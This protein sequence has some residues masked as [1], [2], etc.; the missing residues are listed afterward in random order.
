MAAS[1]ARPTV[2]ALIALALLLLLCLGPG[3]WRDDRALARVI[4]DGVRAERPNL[5]PGKYQKGGRGL[6]VCTCT[7]GSGALGPADGVPGSSAGSPTWLGHLGK[8]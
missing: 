4:G 7:S 6:G 3:K 8:E 1:S 5:S 2:L